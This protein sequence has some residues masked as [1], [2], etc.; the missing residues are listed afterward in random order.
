MMPIGSRK[1]QKELQKKVERL[2][3]EVK[4]L[5]QKIGKLEEDKASKTKT[6]LEFAALV[7]EL[8]GAILAIVLLML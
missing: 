5:E 1:E 8:V 2:E 4:L 7:I 3:A 6:I